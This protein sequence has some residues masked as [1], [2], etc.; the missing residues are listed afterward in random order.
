[1]WPHCEVIKLLQ[2]RATAENE[3]AAPRL[4]FN[5]PS[6]VYKAGDTLVVTATAT[7]A[8]DGYLY[9]D[10]LDND[11]NVIHLL[12]APQ[13]LVNAMKGGQSVTIGAPKTG[14]RKGERVYEISEPFGP[15]LIIAIS[16][17][18][19]LF[20]PRSDE[21]ENA[22]TYL[23]VLTAALKAAAAGADGKR[24]MATHAFINTVPR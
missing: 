6:L 22:K 16:S 13:H 17:P 18:K 20:A 9:V 5:I 15:N 2:D 4:Q 19:P 21:V 12:P 11:A 24:V 7:T 23:P 1:G 8:Y 10:Y 14:G 3:A